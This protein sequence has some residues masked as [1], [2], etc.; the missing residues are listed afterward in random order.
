MSKMKKLTN[1]DNIEID[2]GLCTD[3]LIAMFISSNINKT[4]GIIWFVLGLITAVIKIFS[5][6]SK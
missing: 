3:T 6:K 4:W 2:V 1:L 5:K